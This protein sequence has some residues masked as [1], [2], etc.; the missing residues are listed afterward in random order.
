VR[1]ARKSPLDDVEVASHIMTIM[2]IMCTM[3]LSVSGPLLS[4][5]SAEADP[6]PVISFAI[7]TLVVVVVLLFVILIMFCELQSYLK[8]RLR[9]ECVGLQ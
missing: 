4:P 9:S 3:S 8:R 5:A 1:P 7:F 6:R 2:G